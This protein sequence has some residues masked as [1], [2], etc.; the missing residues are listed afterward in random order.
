MLHKWLFLTLLVSLF[1]LKLE[2]PCVM[3]QLLS[4]QREFTVYSNV[5]SSLL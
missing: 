3:T 4:D 2:K 1:A 5:T